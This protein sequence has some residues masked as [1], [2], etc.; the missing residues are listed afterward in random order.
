MSQILQE[1]IADLLT[2][3]CFHHCGIGDT[4]EHETAMEEAKPFVELFMKFRDQP[5]LF[6]EKP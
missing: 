5:D 4:V 1:K 6:K 3:N 2:V